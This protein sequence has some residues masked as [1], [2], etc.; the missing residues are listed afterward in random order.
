MDVKTILCYRCIIYHTIHG[1]LHEVV[2]QGA[3]V[4]ESI[5][6]CEDEAIGKT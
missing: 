5:P 1:L 2:K 6:E 4:P 3:A